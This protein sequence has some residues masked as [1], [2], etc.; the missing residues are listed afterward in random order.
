M[1]NL[2]VAIKIW[3]YYW[4]NKSITVECDNSGMVSVLNT[5]KS[6]DLVLAAIVIGYKTF[7]YLIDRLV[8]RILSLLSL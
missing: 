6:R 1:L 2:L 7:S 4:T 3:V 8:T 5:G